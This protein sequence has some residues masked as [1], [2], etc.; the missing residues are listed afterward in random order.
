M[1]PDPS[2]IATNICMFI[3]G[4]PITITSWSEVL[5]QLRCAMRLKVSF[6]QREIGSPASSL[7]IAVSLP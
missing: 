7:V 2:S 5:E 3:G 4:L 1:P 6:C